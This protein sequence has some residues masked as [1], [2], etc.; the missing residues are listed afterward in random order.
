MNH[1]AAS[2]DVG[3]IQGLARAT[4][5]PVVTQSGNSMHLTRC[6]R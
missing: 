3:G 4:A 1:P 5:Q 6:A 2:V